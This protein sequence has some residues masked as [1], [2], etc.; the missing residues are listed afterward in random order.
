MIDKSKAIVL[1]NWRKIYEPSDGY[2]PPENMVTRIA[3]NCYGHP[4]HPEGKC[5]IAS[6]VIEIDGRYFKGNSGRVYK[7]DDVQPEYRQWCDENG[8]VLNED[9]PLGPP[10]KFTD[11]R[12]VK[13]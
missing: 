7:L 2:T 11:E 6:E 4:N 9:A 8:L 12:Q 13:I 5:I 1:K 10:K 3:G